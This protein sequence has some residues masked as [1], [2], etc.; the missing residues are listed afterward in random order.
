M[1]KD[2]CYHVSMNNH[3]IYVWKEQGVAGSGLPFY[4]GQGTHSDKRKKY[5]R[6]F[7]NHRITGGISYAQKNAN[8]LAKLGI[9]HIV[10]ILYDNITQDEADE[11]EKS[12]II[13]LGRRINNTG[14]L[15]NISEGA[16]FKP[17]VVDAIRLKRA[18]TLRKTLSDRVKSPLNYRTFA[19]VIEE[20]SVTRYE[21]DGVIYKS[22]SEICKIFNITR[23]MYYSRSSK[24]IDLIDSTNSTS[25]KQV[26]YDGITYSSYAELARA[27]NMRTNRVWQL[28]KEGRK[29]DE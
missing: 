16:D 21:Y 22:I 25:K 17:H 6:A 10:E 19:K 11:L 5:D 12:L 7:T 27:F 18:D 14:I 20:L 3:Y 9:P 15:C 24:G 1:L 8:K 29:L 28:L 2:K 4:I 13:R 23:D 26:V